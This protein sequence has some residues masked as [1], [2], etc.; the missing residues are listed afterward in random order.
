MSDR[1]DE[2]SWAK[3]LDSLRGTPWDVLLIAQSSS[4]LAIDTAHFD[5][6]YTSDVYQELSDGCQQRNW[7][8]IFEK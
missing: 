1:I 4:P 7:I 6:L 3:V 2:R 5:G 8:Q